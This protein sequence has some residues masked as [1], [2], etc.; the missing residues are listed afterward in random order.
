MTSTP[1]DPPSTSA[2]DVQVGGKHY[3]TAIQH[4]DYVIANDIPYLEAQ[5]IKYVSRWRSKNGMEDLKKALHF[6]NKLIE[7]NSCSVAPDAPAQSSDETIR[8]SVRG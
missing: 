1:T 4:W 3:R 7:V 8:A 6:L 2:N 5:I